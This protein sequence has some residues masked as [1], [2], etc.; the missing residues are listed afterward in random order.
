MQ[1]VRRRIAVAQG[2]QCT[3][4]PGSRENLALVAAFDGARA[5]A[6]RA[7]TKRLRQQNLGRSVRALSVKQMGNRGLFA[8]ISP[9]VDHRCAL[10][11]WVCRVIGAQRCVLPAACPAPDHRPLPFCRPHRGHSRSERK[12]RCCLATALDWK[13]H[14]HRASICCSYPLVSAQPE[15]SCRQHG[16]LRLALRIG[17]RSGLCPTTRPSYPK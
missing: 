7:Q 9:T 1:D 6:M 5:L 3:S 17:Q 13:L 15:R 10:R 12:T 2:A 4:L 8:K 16:S 14:R 11:L